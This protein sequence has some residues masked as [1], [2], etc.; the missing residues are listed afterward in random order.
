MDRP[1]DFRD[2]QRPNDA[3]LLD[4]GLPHHGLGPQRRADADCDRRADHLRGAAGRGLC[5]R[6]DRKRILLASD[7]L[8]AIIIFLIPFLAPLSI[9]WLYV[10]VALSSA[11]TQFFD[12]AH[13]SV[14]PE[15]ASDEELSAANS[16][17]AISSVGSTTVG[18]AAAGFLASAQNIDVAFFANS[19]TYADFGGARLYH[20]DIP[21]APRWKTRA[22]GRSAEPASRACVTVRDVPILRSLFLIVVPIFLIFGLQNTLFLPF[23]LKTLGGTEFEFGL[24]QA[25]EA[26]GIALGS[27]LMARLADRIREGQWLV[28]SYVLMAFAGIAYAFSTTHGLAIFLIGVAGFVNAPSFIGR[29]LV[30]Q[31]ATPRGDARAGEQRI[32]RCPGRH[33]RAGHVHGGPGG[34]YQP[35]SADVREFAGGCWRGRGRPGDARLGQPAAEWKRLLSCYRQRGRA[36]WARA[37]PRPWKTSTGSSPAGPSWQSMGEKERRRLAAETLVARHPEARWW[38]TGGS[39]Q[40]G[41]LHSEGSVGVGYIKNDEYVILSHPARRR[42]LWRGGGAH[43][44]VRTANVITEEES[45]FLIIPSKV[46]RRLA[47]R[48]AACRKSSTP[49]WPS[50]SASRTCRLARRSIKDFCGSCDQYA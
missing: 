19:A 33:V 32:L 5:G 48:Y 14:L 24:Q 9:V 38:S 15:L 23:A 44:S 22:S 17:M 4:P 42:F 41:I 28:I 36:G 30:I 34:L 31:R 27:L 40:C 20:A 3:G 12:L 37:S 29:Q 8:R 6:Y 1:T 43:G 45:E 2:G 50:A 39:Q 35:A 47:D 11:I 21:R 18:F 25:A 7:I 26:V 13:A 49:R 10:I 46:L 16:L